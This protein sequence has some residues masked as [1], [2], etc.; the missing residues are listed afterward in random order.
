MLRTALY[1]ENE[2]FAAQWLQNLIK[3]GHINDGAV[4]DRDVRVLRP[5]DVEGHAQVHYF[6]GIGCW[7]HAL[8]LAGWSDDR[9]VWTASLPCQPWSTAGRRKGTSDERHLWPTFFRLVK[10]CRPGVL[11]G[12][13]VGSPAGRAWLDIVQDD[14]EKAGYAVGAC[15]LPASSCGAPHIRQRLYFVAI[16]DV[17]RREGKRIQLR[18]G[19]PRQAMPEVSWSGAPRLLGDAGSPRSRRD[20]GAVLGEKAPGDQEGKQAR[21][22]SHEP[23]SPSATLVLGDA[24]RSRSQVRSRKD[25]RSRTLR[26]EGSAA[27]EA[28]IVGGPWAPAD[29]V[30]C[31]DGKYRPVEPI[32]QQMADG[33]TES[34]G[35][36]RAETLREIEEEVAHAIRHETDAREALLDLWQALS[37]EA[38]A[39]RETGVL[40]SVH[41]AP[42][43]LAFMRQLANQGWSLPQGISRPSQEEKEI[44]LRMLSCDQPPSR[45]PRRRELAKQLGGKSSN[46]MRILSS[47]LARHAQAAWDEAIEANA[48]ATF[49]LFVDA[50][51]RVGRLRAVG[52]AICPQVAA[53]FIASVMD[54]LDAGYAG[55][56]AGGGVTTP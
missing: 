21:Y 44:L 30:Y 16:A 51:S 35:R 42:V 54:V 37:T 50:P 49:P 43:L 4:D 31:R 10:K 33:S 52:N 11:L 17:Q 5:R 3:A 13:Q 38:N 27:A 47:I 40:S 19:Q 41:G 23:V 48:R 56:D 14:L 20:A 18:S 36:V 24:G 32:T 9:P 39:E 28:G 34:M 15:N 26:I 29:L 6:A 12:E 2:P 7:S 1:N 46:A 45:T 53:T 22:L 55:Y 25:E 8:R